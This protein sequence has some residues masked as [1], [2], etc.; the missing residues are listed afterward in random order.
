LHLAAET[1]KK[2]KEL[3]ALS[4]RATDEIV[5]DAMAGFL[6]KCN[7]FAR[8]FTAATTTEKRQSKAYPR[9]QGRSPLSPKK[10]R[11]P[12]EIGFM[13]QYAFHPDARDDFLYTRH[14]IPQPGPD[15]ERG[16]HVSS[17]YRLKRL[18]FRTT[19]SFADAGSNM[20]LN[21]TTK[22]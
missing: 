22:F 15:D 5:E 2:L 17:F 19:I 18:F 9:R 4:G 6:P 12:F 8:P 3:S 16:L 13:T 20:L 14:S 11:R 1:E 7:R 10:R 21:H